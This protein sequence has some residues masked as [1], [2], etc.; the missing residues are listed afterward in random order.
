MRGRV[1]SLLY[2]CAYSHAKHIVGAQ[3][4][5]KWGKKGRKERWEREGNGG[6]EGGCKEGRREGNLAYSVSLNTINYL[7]SLSVLPSRKSLSEFW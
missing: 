7:M 6:R 5:F 4:I 1:C 2:P 3:K